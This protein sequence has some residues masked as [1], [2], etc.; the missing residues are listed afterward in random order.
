MDFGELPLPAEHVC[1]YHSGEH[2]PTLLL[3]LVGP[4]LLWFPG[5]ALLDSM[6]PETFSN[7][8]DFMILQIQTTPFSLPQHLPPACPATGALKNQLL[9]QLGAGVA[10]AF[11][12]W[13]HYIWVT[14]VC[15]SSARPCTSVKP[16]RQAPYMLKI[17]YDPEGK[18]RASHKSLHNPAGEHQIS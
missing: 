2:S 5:K 15:K 8:D 1:T 14:L 11:L 13:Y 18:S 9:G 7:P 17:P 10:V 4:D 16:S 6:I 3:P 12:S